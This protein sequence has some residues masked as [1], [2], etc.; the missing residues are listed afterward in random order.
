MSYSKVD[1]LILSISVIWVK[2]LTFFPLSITQ[3]GLRSIGLIEKIS[4]LIENKPSFHQGF[5][6]CN[7]KVNLFFEVPPRDNH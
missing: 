2:S 7:A 6:R 5:R 4:A 3:G 1:L